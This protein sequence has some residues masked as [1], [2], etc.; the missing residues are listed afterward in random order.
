[1][2]G[3]EFRRL[4]ESLGYSQAMLSREIDV[5]IRGISRWEN[6]EVPIPKIGELALKYVA[7]K[8]ERKAK[9]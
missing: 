5:S 2:S 1:M 9:Q 6:D 8:R 4:R 3:K 7:E